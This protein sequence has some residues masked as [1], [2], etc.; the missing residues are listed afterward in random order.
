MFGK[1][2]SVKIS[3]SVIPSEA[4]EERMGKTASVK[5]SRW[6]IPELLES[7]KEEQPCRA[8]RWVKPELLE[9]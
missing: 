9:S 5:T 3:R 4:G 2:A 6:V 1:R 7:R 8:S